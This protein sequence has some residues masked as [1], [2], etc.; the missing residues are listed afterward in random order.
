MYCEKEK[1]QK[2]L[3]KDKFLYEFNPKNKKKK[4]KLWF[5]SKNFVNKQNFIIEQILLNLNIKKRRR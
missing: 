4:R 2:I 1:L 3:I 5:F